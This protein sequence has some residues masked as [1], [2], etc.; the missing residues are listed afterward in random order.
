MTARDLIRLDATKLVGRDTKFAGIDPDS[1]A[2]DVWGS[3][4]GPLVHLILGQQVSIEAADAMYAN[5]GRQ[6]GSITPRGLL[7][8]D[9]ETL[10]RCGFT[11][12]KAECGRGLAT[13]CLEGF[14]LE[15]L[16]E[17]PDDLV[18]E[19]LVGI[20]GIGRWTAECYLLFCLG[21]RDVY[22]AGDLALR[23]GYQEL[24]DAPERPTES[25]LA[26]AAEQWQP[27]RTAAAYLTW[28]G[29]LRRRGRVLTQGRSRPTYG[30]RNN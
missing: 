22:P 3:G 15:E 5:L 26:K 7:S 11:R 29:Y 25:E 23:I 13:V 18:V 6:L 12:M 28:Q 27:L 21:R 24:V 8:L 2:I 9:D 20:R 30:Y 1:L 16:A 14:S 10:R 4:F 17:Q 19:A